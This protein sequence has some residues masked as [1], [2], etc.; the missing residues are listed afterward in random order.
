MSISESFSYLYLRTRDDDDRERV[1]GFF[2]ILN[3]ILKNKKHPFVSDGRGF[4]GYKGSTPLDKTTL[5]KTRA[6]RRI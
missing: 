3:G 2:K 6:K 4:S 1:Y 5:I